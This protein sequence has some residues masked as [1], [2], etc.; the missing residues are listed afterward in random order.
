[1]P[2]LTIAVHSALRWVVLAAGVVAVARFAVGWLR[3]S[4][5]SRLDDRLTLAFAV[6]LDVQWVVGLVLYLGVS[7]L[8][9]TA[10]AS[11]GVRVVRSPELRFWAIVHPLLAT[12]ALAIAHGA[13]IRLRS[14][15]APTARHRL[16]ALSFGVAVALVVAA[17]R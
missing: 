11:E 4:G 14:V 17:V 9:M 7:V 1:M 15:A 6:S 5:W 3:G 2:H 13:R 16:T 10:L 12:A 8:G